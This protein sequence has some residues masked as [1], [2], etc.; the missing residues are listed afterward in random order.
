MRKKVCGSCGFIGRPVHDEYSSLVMD[1]FVWTASLVIA[2]I[3]G[4]I[5]LAILGPLFSV[6]H[7][8]TFRSH[9]CPKCGNWEMHRIHESKS[10]QHT[11]LGFH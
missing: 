2:F 6:W 3:T 5:Y 10:R 8:A 7:M 9:R 4:I 1:A 11:P